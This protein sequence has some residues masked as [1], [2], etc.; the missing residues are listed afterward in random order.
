MHIGMHCY[1]AN[2]KY[3]FA[4][5]TFLRRKSIVICTLAFLSFLILWIIWGNVTVGVTRYTVASTSLP[6][7][8]DGYRI[9]VV[10]DL[11]NAQFGKGNVQLIEKIE[12]AQPDIIAITGDLIDSNR[13]DIDVAVRT[14]NQLTQIA[15]CYFVTGNHEAWIKGQYEE[16]EKQLI[17]GGVVILHD[18]V[19]QLSRGK[20]TIQIAG[21][22]DP[23]FSDAGPYALDS[24]FEAKIRRMPLSADY[25]ILLSHRPELFNAYVKEDADLILSGHAHGGQFRISFVGGLVAPDQGLFPKYDAGLFTEDNTTMIVSRGIGNSIIPVRFNNRPEIVVVE[26]KCL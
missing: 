4:R 21:L 19:V 11:H 3:E 13:T 10:S 24:I 17:A 16:L 18:Q 9:A 1:G 5:G 8:F 14:V 26:L 12:K 6:R 23:D 22:D 25:C 20:G 15:T 7:N 2:G